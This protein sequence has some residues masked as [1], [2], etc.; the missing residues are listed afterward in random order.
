MGERIR[1]IAPGPSKDCPAGADSQ[2]QNPLHRDERRSV[3]MRGIATLQDNRK[4][5]VVLVN[6]SYDGCA[7]ESAVPLTEGS[8]LLLATR[9]GIIDAEVRWV[10]G[11][12]AGLHFKTEPFG[13]IRKIAE[14]A[15]RDCERVSVDLSAK[16]KRFGRG[17]CVVP[18]SDVSV[19]GCK[20]EFAD[21]PQVGESVFIRF[22]GLDSIEA[23]VCWV[24]DRDCGLDFVCPIH[25][26]ILE[27]L[28]QRH[29]RTA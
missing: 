16:M 11:T 5:P 12:H 21:R 27:L 26:A 8:A 10:S 6:L 23:T 22:D 25:P 17:C 9:G 7:V 3:E 15:A 18:I 24:G 2:Q 29:S 1:N 28:L 19:T 14:S 20:V 4:I 13:P